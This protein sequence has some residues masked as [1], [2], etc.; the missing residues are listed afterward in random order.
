M[1]FY[2]EELIPQDAN[3]IAWAD[4][5]LVYRMIEDNPEGIQPIDTGGGE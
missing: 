3:D 2:G 1:K 4:M 5:A